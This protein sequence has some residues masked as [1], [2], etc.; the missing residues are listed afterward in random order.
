MKKTGKLTLCMIVVL[1][2]SLMA[3]NTLVWAADGNYGY[4][5]TEVGTFEDPDWEVYVIE[6][7]PVIPTG[8]GAH[9]LT[10]M[11][12]AVLED[13]YVNLEYLGDGFYEVASSMEEINSTGLI[14]GEG[15]E[16]IPCE[17]AMISVPDYEGDGLP[18]FLE[19]IY[20]TGETD[21]LNEAFFYT[22]EGYFS[23]QP[24]EDDTLYTGYGK[25][26]DLQEKQFVEGIEITNSDS[27]A[28]TVVGNTFLLEDEDGTTT[29]YDAD[30]NALLQTD[31]Y[32]EAGCGVF[33]FDRTA[34][35]ENGEVTYE[36]D[37]SISPIPGPR[38]L[39]TE[40]TGDG[41][42]VLE[43]NGK[44]VYDGEYEYVRW[45]DGSTLTVT[46]D[47]EGKLIYADGTVVTTIGKYPEKVAYGFYSVWD[48]DSEQNAM[49]YPDG[50]EVTGVSYGVDELVIDD[51]NNNLFIINDEDYTFQPQDSYPDTMTYGMIAD[52]TEDDMYGVIDLFTGEELLPYEY[53]EVAYAAGYVYAYKL[54]DGF[55]TV[56]EVNGPVA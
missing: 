23:I 52:C 46:E 11:G 55:W 44:Q 24:G 17:A 31:R 38:G 15:E 22:Y 36:S 28:L 2:V 14:N 18:R 19:I 21:D 49:Y 43:K 1:L 45:E 20:A 42:I 40:Y 29:L 35:D 39:I 47:G 27:N 9:L 51:D 32:V 8:N 30:G 7:L 3:G 48:S 12:E 13:E 25:V 56:Y 53:D 5:L 54:S 26:F 6:E 37:S 16:L 4:T 41:Y 50:R 33:T 10:L 34:Y